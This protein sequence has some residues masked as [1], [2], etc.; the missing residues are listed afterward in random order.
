MLREQLWD[1]KRSIGGEEE[2]KLQVTAIPPK[3]LK[4]IDCAGERGQ[5]MVSAEVEFLPAFDH[6]Q[7]PP[8]WSAGK[9]K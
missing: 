9:S 2:E 1:V 6:T 7:S 8:P 5:Q 4:A 3:A